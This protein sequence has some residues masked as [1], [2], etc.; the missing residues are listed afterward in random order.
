MNTFVV[1]LYDLCKT[2]VLKINHSLNDV[3][4]LKQ[5]VPPQILEDLIECHHANCVK[6]LICYFQQENFIV[7]RECFKI[8][9]SNYLN[10]EEVVIFDTGKLGINYERFK[11]GLCPFSCIE[12]TELICAC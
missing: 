11:C 3:K 9:P 1:S 7:C 8:N 6:V 12:Q 5:C 2:V 10:S 4:K